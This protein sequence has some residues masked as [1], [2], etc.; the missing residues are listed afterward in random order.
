M[1]PHA[2]SVGLFSLALCLNACGRSGQDFLSNLF[3]SAISDPSDPVVA[4]VQDVKI[5]RSDLMMRFE[6]LPPSEKSTLQS[7]PQGKSTVLNRLINQVLLVEAAEKTGFARDKNIQRTLEK[8]RRNL[9]AASYRN[10]LLATVASVSE[11]EAR[12]YYDD[13]SKYKYGPGTEIQASRVVLRSPEDAA[14]AQDLL[15]MKKPFAEVARTLSIDK[16]T[17]RQ[18]G[19]LPPFRLG[20]RSPAVESAVLALR[21]G[22]ISGIVK[23]PL[24]LQIIRR[25]SV[26]KKPAIPFEEVKEEIR[27][28][29]EQQ[30]LNAWL[31][32]AKVATP[33][34]VDQKGLESIEFTVPLSSTSR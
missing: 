9:L 14:K 4:R 23:T 11:A 32:R 8:Q 22:E 30:K 1:R 29:L 5:R 12:R 21:D 3:P 33:I 16:E 2:L 7:A 17:A 31:D 26:T 20:T 6:D 13:Q 15:K 28:F 24:G 27:N 19:K 18:G 25:E 34:E 10:H